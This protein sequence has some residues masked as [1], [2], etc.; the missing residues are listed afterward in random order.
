M[1]RTRNGW[2]LALSMIFL[3]AAVSIPDQVP[4]VSIGILPFQDESGTQVPA[5]VLSKIAQDIARK[6]ILSYQDVLAR[7]IGGES[8]TA[9]LGVDQ[10]AA[11]VKQQG[12]RFILRGGI[13]ALDSEKVDKT[14]N[15]R[16]GLYAELI[17]GEGGAIS[18]LRANGAGTEENAAIDDA[19]HWEGYDF[20]SNAFA[21]TALGRALGAAVDQIVPQ[22]REAALSPGQ[23]AA[24]A[25]PADQPPVEPAAEEAW[26]SYEADQ[27][28]QQLIAQA[29]S[30][31]AG[32]ATAGMDIAPLQQSIEAL[33]SALN[34]KISLMEQGQDT[35][36]ADQAIEQRKAELQAA[37]DAFTQAAAAE[38]PQTEPQPVTG[39]KK[40]IIQKVSGLLDD[41]LAAVLKIQEIKAALQGAQQEEQA[42][43]EP[44]VAE[45][46]AVPAEEPA[47]PVE[48]PTTDVGGVVVDESGDPVEG[49]VVTDPESGAEATTDSSGSYHIPR[50]PGGRIAE[51]L[52]TKDG[53]RLSAGK[54]HLLA[55]RPAFADWRAGSGGPGGSAP[56]SLK[57]LPSNIILPPKAGVRTADLGTVTGVARDEQGRPVGRAVVMIQGVGTARTDSLGRYSFVN[58]PQGNYKGIVQRGGST[59]QTFQVNVV[60]KK[61]VENKILVSSKTAARPAL[62]PVALAKGSGTLLKGTVISEEK[63]ALGGAKVTA[64]VSGGGGLSV[65]TGGN[66]IYEFKDLKPGSYRLL[67]KKAGFQEASQPVVLQAGRGEVRNFSL[68]KSSAQIQKAILSTTPRLTAQ[69][70]GTTPGKTAGTTARTTAGTT[71]GKVAGTAPAAGYLQ[72]QVL[73]A[74][75]RK[76]V[77]NASVQAAG[78]PAVST[79]SQGKYRL[80]NLPPGGTR[81]VVVHK[82]FQQAEKTVTIRAGG[83][84]QEDFSLRRRELPKLE[85]AP[86]VATPKIQVTFGQVR[87]RVTD[88]KTG[89]PIA[90]ASVTLSNRTAQSNASGDYSFANVAAGSYTLTFKKSGYQDGSSR[91][92]VTAGKTATADVRLTPKALMDIRKK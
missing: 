23:E 65:L 37:V 38:P 67:A 91:V 72:G 78:R 79:D 75:N 69:P 49:A 68:K 14:L 53:R 81:V 84:S 44:Q 62:I 52:V 43:A 7:V 55:G 51:L 34:D 15:C 17:A 63:R 40:N 76:P 26:A 24:V 16:V 50:I 18:N 73:D 36:A 88:A 83:T 92:T 2:W 56:M 77:A 85:A 39:E 32:G 3:S 87:G 80:N 71:A 57:I 30:L 5:D 82:D 42:Q 19:R 70:A 74:G 90:Q 66:G 46:P 86:R 47:A 89:K 28:L 12:V 25:V 29:E 22:V 33:R 27:E 4:V 13:L 6:L 1:K 58:V 45:D 31:V 48:E 59:V 10:L 35:A 8:G 9:G 54:V 61:S 20:G 64:V 41:T 21:A 60:A 11:L